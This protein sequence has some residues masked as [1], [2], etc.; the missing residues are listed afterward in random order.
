MLSQRQAARSSVEK[1]WIVVPV[2]NLVPD[3]SSYL[4]PQTDELSKT[5]PQAHHGILI[6]AQNC[7]SHQ[8]A[9]KTHAQS[10]NTGTQPTADHVE[11]ARHLTHFL[12]L[13]H[14]HQ[15][16][17]HTPPVDINTSIALDQTPSNE[18]IGRPPL[19]PS[20]SP[21]HRQV[22]KNRQTDKQYDPQSSSHG[23]QAYLLLPK[24]FYLMQGSSLFQI[25]FCI[26]RKRPRQ[27]S[28]ST[29]T[30]WVTASFC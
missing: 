1:E 27:L 12:L 6:K 14:R 17:K 22:C 20:P 21:S 26:K 23:N 18:D 19:Q 4:Q 7:L 2:T 11:G 28:H 30:C 25:P 3:T 5:W 10:S 9:L 8:D 16:V 29:K 24:S 15:L 13:F